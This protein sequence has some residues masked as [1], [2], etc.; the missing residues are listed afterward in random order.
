MKNLWQA[1][2]Q[3][4]EDAWAWFTGA[5]DAIRRDLLYHFIAGLLIAALFGIT[6]RMGV[7]AI[8]PALF[9]GFIKEFIDGFVGSQFDW[10]DLAAVVIGGAVISLCFLLVL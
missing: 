9:V 5:L 2:R 8:V 3:F 4:F 6:F 1:I 7:W 10:K